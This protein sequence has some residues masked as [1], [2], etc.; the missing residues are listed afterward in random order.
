[1]AEFP[2]TRWSVIARARDPDSSER[3]RA[4]EEFCP[5]TTGFR[6]T[7]TPVLAENHAHDAEDLVQGFIVRL[8]EQPQKFDK[9]DLGARGVA[10]VAENGVS[11]LHD[12]RL[13]KESGRINA[14]VA[15]MRFLSMSIELRS[16]SRAV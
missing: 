8:I 12:R 9:L 6:S 15:R 10:R 5:G 13:G 2:E 14:A 7:A 4:L 16:G 11:A 1:M 3:R